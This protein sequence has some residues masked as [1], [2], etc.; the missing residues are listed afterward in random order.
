MLLNI[1]E[2][3]KKAASKL[4][5]LSSLN[6]S[7]TCDVC[8]APYK[9]K[10]AAIKHL[11]R[12][13]PD[14]IQRL[15]ETVMREHAEQQR[16]NFI[17]EL[18]MLPSRAIE[19]YEKD[20]KDFIDKVKD[21]YTFIYYARQRLEKLIKLEA[22]VALH[23]ETSEFIRNAHCSWRELLA[24]LEAERDK[25]IYELIIFPAEHNS[26]S[27]I[28]NVIEMWRYKAQCNFYKKDVSS[29]MGDYIHTLRKI[30][31]ADSFLAFAPVQ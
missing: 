27:A 13:H 12:E 18:A 23:K 15:T 10:I 31:E 8:G 19:K 14:V 4:L 3:R 2:A 29:A 22:T 9:R 30:I 7:F 1:D 28:S 17:R 25:K 24:D 20:K 6:E 5:S 21:D 26:T 16:D 11:Y